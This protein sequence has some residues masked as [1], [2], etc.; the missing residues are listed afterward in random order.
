MSNV[1]DS[2]RQENL[3]TDLPAFQI[4]DTVRCQMKITE[5]GKTR[6]QNYEGVVMAQSGTANEESITVR[7]ISNGVA[8]ERVIPLHTPSLAGIEL[9][10]HGRVRRAKLYY[11]RGLT[12]RKARIRERRIVK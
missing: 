8:V 11:L 7:K 12:G 5:G 9:V 3:K 1:I 4:G 6:V 2:L 10:R